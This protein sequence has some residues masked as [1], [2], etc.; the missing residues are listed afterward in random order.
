MKYFRNHNTCN[1]RWLTKYDQNQL[2]TTS[3][4]H[5]DFLIH[6]ERFFCGRLRIKTAVVVTSIVDAIFWSAVVVRGIL[7][8]ANVTN[9]ALTASWLTFTVPVCWVSYASSAIATYAI[10]GRH[11]L[12]LLP[13]LVVK[14]ATTLM[15]TVFAFFIIYLAFVHPQQC[16]DVTTPFHTEVDT[17][18]LKKAIRIGASIF[19]AI[20]LLFV[21]MEVWFIRILLKS[22]KQCRLYYFMSMLYK[23]KPLKAKSLK[24]F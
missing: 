24:T 7:F 9:N 20:M 6:N 21:C 19:L 3:D 1:S 5:F 17:L 23:A 22:Y 4:N 10:C 2:T 11:Y 16:M 15:C 12:L 13:Q 8:Y 18:W 14:I